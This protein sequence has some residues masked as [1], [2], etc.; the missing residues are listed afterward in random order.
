[1]FVSLL[2]FNVVRIIVIIVTRNSV[3]TKANQIPV[4]F[5][6]V[7]NIRTKGTIIM[8]PRVMDTKKASFARS[9]ALKYAAIIIL[10]PAKKK[11]TK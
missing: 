8:H 5:N 10:T 6:I 4:I 1:M 2:F 11:P 7:L 3:I 9:V